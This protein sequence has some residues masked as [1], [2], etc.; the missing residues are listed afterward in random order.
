MTIKYK[1]NKDIIRHEAMSLYF[2]FQTIK[3]SINIYN[4][5]KEINGKSLIGIFKGNLNQN[6]IIKIKSS[7]KNSNRIKEILNNYGREV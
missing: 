3:D 2:Y 1:L 4:N 5:K 7:S 6:D